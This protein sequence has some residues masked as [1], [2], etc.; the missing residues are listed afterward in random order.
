MFAVNVTKKED[1]EESITQFVKEHGLMFEAL[2][3]KKAVASSVYQVIT[4]PTTYT[5]DTKENVVDAIKGPMMEAMIKDVIN[6]LD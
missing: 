5:I 6:K 4:L 2:L 1:G 3:D